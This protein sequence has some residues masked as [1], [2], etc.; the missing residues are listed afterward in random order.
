MPLGDSGDDECEHV[1]VKVEVGGG[2][3]DELASGGGGC[4]GNFL[5]C[6]GHKNQCNVH[7]HV[8]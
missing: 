6:H 4:D 8:R 2:G 1:G 7:V 3:G 5:G